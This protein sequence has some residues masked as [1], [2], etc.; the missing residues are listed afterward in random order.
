MANVTQEF[1]LDKRYLTL[2]FIRL[3]LAFV[4]SGFVKEGITIWRRMIVHRNNDDQQDCIY[5]STHE[6]QTWWILIQTSNKSK[7]R[8]NKNKVLASG[9][10]YVQ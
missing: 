5:V 7:V 8:W 3:G 4:D 2:V 6:E 1:N 9:C 10:T